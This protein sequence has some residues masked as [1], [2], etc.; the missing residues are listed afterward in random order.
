[1]M[2]FIFLSKRSEICKDKRGVW[3]LQ[4]TA[5]A[6][7][8]TFSFLRYFC[9]RKIFLEIFRFRKIVA[10][11]YVFAKVWTKTS[12]KNFGRGLIK[13]S[14]TKKFSFLRKFSCQP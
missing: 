4:A 7:F 13:F 6:N 12:P 10:K 1:L 9:F 5:M 2:T 3:N 14:F 11:T 8:R